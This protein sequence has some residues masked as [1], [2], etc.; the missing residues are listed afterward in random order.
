MDLGWSV[1]DESLAYNFRELL[2][3]EFTPVAHSASQHRAWLLTN[4]GKLAA[5]DRSPNDS[6]TRWILIPCKLYGGSPMEIF[7]ALHQNSQGFHR[8]DRYIG[9][10]CSAKAN[11]A[12]SACSSRD[13]S[14]GVTINMWLREAA[15]FWL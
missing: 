15:F 6:I 11:L 10:F 1:S 3:V 7:A 8:L 5:I 14:S 9:Q 4:V 12:C 13:M 2:Q